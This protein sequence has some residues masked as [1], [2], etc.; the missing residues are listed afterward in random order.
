MSTNEELA[1]EAW[2]KLVQAP[3]WVVK[4]DIILAA[5]TTATAERDREIAE[6][7]DRHLRLIGS[8][9]N[10]YPD[11]IPASERAWSQHVIAELHAENTQLRE[12]I[13]NR[14]P[15]KLPPNS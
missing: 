11:T 3:A 9:S 4:Y 12:I 14:A 1:R 13:A 7:K 8:L 10:G 6:L 5:L 2:S 15:C